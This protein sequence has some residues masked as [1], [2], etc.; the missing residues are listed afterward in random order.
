LAPVR[1]VLGART[2]AVTAGIV[3]RWNL[4]CCRR[5]RSAEKGSRSVLML[6]AALVLAGTDAVEALGFAR[7]AWVSLGARDVAIAGIVAR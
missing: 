5:F 4:A 2:V 1:A 7:V 6:V 3:A